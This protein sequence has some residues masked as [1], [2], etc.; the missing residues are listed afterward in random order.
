MK[1]AAER[2]DHGQ[3]EVMAEHVVDVLMEP[4]AERWDHLL[5]E[6]DLVGGKVAAM[7]PATIGGITYVNHNVGPPPQLT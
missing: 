7:E 3:A 4:A 1:P 6:H 5:Q 2:Q